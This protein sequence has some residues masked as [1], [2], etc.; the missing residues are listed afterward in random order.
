[1]ILSHGVPY[2][3]LNDC[4]ISTRTEAVQNVVCHIL[5]SAME[6]SAPDPGTHA[7]NGGHEENKTATNFVG[8]WNPPYVD[9]TLKYRQS[10]QFLNG[11][12]GGSHEENVIQ[13]AASI[14]VSQRNTG[15]F[16]D[17]CPG[18]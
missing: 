18:S 2:C 13:S 5:S 3:Q 9:K 1:M 12:I 7:D 17:R 4:L 8:D 16:A 15:V 10:Y 6:L 11:I 14:H